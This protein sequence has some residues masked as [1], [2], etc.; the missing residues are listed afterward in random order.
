[1]QKSEVKEKAA[2]IYGDCKQ[3]V[4]YRFG[5]NVCHSEQAA[6]LRENVT[7]SG[8]G[9]PDKAWGMHLLCGLCADAQ[10]IFH[11]IKI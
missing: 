4:T 11:T 1:M 9:E 8:S 7:G 2:E 5:N 3:Q 6:D 10:P